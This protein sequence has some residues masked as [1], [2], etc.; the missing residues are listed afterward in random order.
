LLN[1][2]PLGRSQLQAEDARACEQLLI[3]FANAIDQR[4][5]ERVV[6]L[7]AER[8]AFVAADL[9]RENRDRIRSFLDLRPAKMTNRHLLA[10]F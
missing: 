2:P 8:S 6:S 7:F 9:F 10:N 1:L 5:Y 3:G 4:D